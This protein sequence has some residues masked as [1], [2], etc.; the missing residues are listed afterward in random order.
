[1][2]SD[3]DG[4]AERAERARGLEADARDLE[5]HHD[6]GAGEPA[7][8]FCDGMPEIRTDRP[9]RSASRLVVAVPKPRK[10]GGSDASL[11]GRGLTAASR[12]ERPKTLREIVR[13]T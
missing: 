11:R 1:M 10:P 3:G 9:A 4:A 5:R 7:V 12:T 2:R 6:G 8:F 13:A